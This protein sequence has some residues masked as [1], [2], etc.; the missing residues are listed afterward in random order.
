MEELTHKLSKLGIPELTAYPNANP[1]LNPVDIY[2]SHITDQLARITGVDPG[3]ILRAL[4]WTQTLD[5]GDL[6]LPVPALRQKGK[7]PADL[8]VEYAE[9]VCFIVLL[10]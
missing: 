9:K 6:V 8:A 4:Q 3:I 2:R 10:V 1:E 7:K 5:N